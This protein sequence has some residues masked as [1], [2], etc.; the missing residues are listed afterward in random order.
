MD[1][2]LTETKT[3]YSKVTVVVLHVFGGCPIIVVARKTDS[4]SP[5][6]D[7]SIVLK[8]LTKL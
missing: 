8:L 6:G 5:N 2:A 3:C 1:S 4:E 7:F